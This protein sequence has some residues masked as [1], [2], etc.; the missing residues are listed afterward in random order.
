MPNKPLLHYLS[1]LFDIYRLLFSS[2]FIPITV[3][4]K[5]G[6]PQ[7]LVQGTSGILLFRASIVLHILNMCTCDHTWNPRR[8]RKDVSFQT[9]SKRKDC[10]HEATVNNIKESCPYDSSEK[11]HVHLIIKG[12]TRMIHIFT[13]TVTNR[14]CSYNI[15]NIFLSSLYP[16]WIHRSANHPHKY[17]HLIYGKRNEL[18]DN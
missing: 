18:D 14:Y 8:K 15:S 9:G 5:L 16:I 10:V 6:W 13:C 4:R 17:S 3:K 1:S 7:L 12:R 2:N 11:H